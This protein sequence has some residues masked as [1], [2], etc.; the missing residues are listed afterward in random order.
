MSTPLPRPGAHDLAILVDLSSLARGLFHTLPPSQTEDGEPN[1]VTAAVALKLVQIIAKLSP[2]YLGVCADGPTAIGDEESP[3]DARARRYWR[4]KIWPDY[5]AEREPPGGEYDTQ[6]TRLI[7]IC[8]AHRIPVFRGPGMEADDYFGSIVPKL[9]ALGLRVIIVSKDHD[10]WQ[11]VRRGVA[12]WDGDLGGDLIDLRDV[13]KRYG[14]PAGWLPALLALAGDDDEAPGVPHVGADRAAALIQR[15]GQTEGEPLDSAGVL[16]RVLSRW[17]WET[18]TKG[19]YTK[20]ALALRD[21]AADAR[22]SL[23]LVELR[24]ENVP[25]ALDLAALRLGWDEGD[26]EEVRRL[27]D[28]LSIAVLRSCPPRPKL[29]LDD[30]LARR[31]IEAEAAE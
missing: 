2:A 17:G 31:W 28:E 29:P 25:V 18:T 12:C 20:V 4:A 9:R 26:A 23:R 24:E 22:L 15:H 14:V 8:H 30:A 21:H 7:E 11:L 5:K 19:K 16:D 1:A 13:E 10:L 3:A 27:G 6:I